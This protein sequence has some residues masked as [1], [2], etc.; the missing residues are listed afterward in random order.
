MK[1]NPNGVEVR[2]ESDL[3]QLA[4]RAKELFHRARERGQQSVLCYVKLGEVL[5]SAKDQFPHK[6]LDWVDKN[7]KI[8][9]R[10]VSKY[11]LLFQYQSQIKSAAS[12]G[13]ALKVIGKQSKPANSKPQITTKPQK[14]S[15]SK[16]VD[17]AAAGNNYNI[18]EI[19]EEV[20]QVRIL[21]DERMMH[22]RDVRRVHKIIKLLLS[23][24]ESQTQQGEE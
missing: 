17:N 18:K 16:P 10:Q 7:V 19:R 8:S 13:E 12:I 11:L 4:D 1:S 23:I 15:Q 22:P 2:S 21:V 20:D 9:R 14:S 24:V 3:Q 6:Y 5:Q